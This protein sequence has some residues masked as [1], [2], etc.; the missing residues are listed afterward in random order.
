MTP[1]EIFE[2]LCRPFPTA[3]VNWRVGRTNEKWRKEGEPLK[4]EPFCYIDARA[5]MDRLDAV[6]GWNNWQCSYRQEGASTLCNLGI[7]IEGEWIWKE[8][9]AGATDIEAE[10]GALSDAFKRAAVKFGIARYLYDLEAPKI[11]LE[12]RG[13][14]PVIPDAAKDDLR[15]LYNNFSRGL[16]LGQTDGKR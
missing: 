7:K 15:K 1:Q 14:T 10:K 6:V 13:K 11:V 8:D 12:M 5:V 9:G 2:G 4:G 16:M 3:M